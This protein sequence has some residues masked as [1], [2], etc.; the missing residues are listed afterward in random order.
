[1]FKKIISCMFFLPVLLLLIFV[2]ISI[3]IYSRARR[4]FSFGVILLIVA[5]VFTYRDWK[6]AGLLFGVEVGS[7]LFLA[8]SYLLESHIRY[9]LQAMKNHITG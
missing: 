8:V 3:W 2:K 4:L 6:Q 5:T 7:F 1:M 9:I